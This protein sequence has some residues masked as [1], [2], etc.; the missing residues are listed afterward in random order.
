VV[1]SGTV[2]TLPTCIIGP[3]DSRLA[4]GG[5]VFQLKHRNGA[6]MKRAVD[7]GADMSA[8][9]KSFDARP[10]MHVQNAAELFPD[11]PGLHESGEHGGRDC[12]AGARN[13]SCRG[14][15]DGTGMGRGTA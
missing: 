5:V 4:L 9:M 1:A 10:F 11:L 2:P 8:A 6:H 13:G 14:H 3:N 12:Q 7:D 15:N